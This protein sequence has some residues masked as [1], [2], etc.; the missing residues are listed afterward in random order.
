MRGLKLTYSTLGQTRNEA[1]VD[2]LIAALDDPEQ[3]HRDYALDALIKR[4]EERAPELLFKS[5]D[6]VKVEDLPKLRKQKDWV[7]KPIE[8]ALKENGDSIQNAIEAA[9]ALELTTAVTNLAMIAESSA[10]AELK[11]KCSEAIIELVRPLGAA[12]RDDRNQ[13]TVRGPVQQRLFDSVSRFSMHRNERLVDAFLLVSTWG[14]NDLRQMVQETDGPHMELLSSR[15]TQTEEPGILEL[16]AGYIRH[17]NMPH[18]I[19]P[20]LKARGDAKFRNVLLEEVGAEPNS[21]LLRNLGTIGMP[22]CCRGGERL[23]DEVP[24]SLYAALIQ[25][26]AAASDDVQESLQLVA[27]AVVRGGPGVETAAAHAFMRSDV[28]ATEFWMRAAMP[29]GDGDE[30]KIDRDPN[31][32]LLKNL[33]KLLGH[34]NPGLVKSVRRVLEPLHVEQMLSRFQPLRRRSRRR[35]GKVVLMIDPESVEKVKDTLQHSVLSY[36]L[37]AIAAADAFDV[38]DDLADSFKRIIRDDQ[39]EAR[40]RA[41]EALGE[42]SHPN[43]LRLLEEMANLPECPVKDAALV[44]IERRKRQSYTNSSLD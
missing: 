30:A 12:A 21:T 35:L 3:S 22:K 38:V 39:Q 15:L 7:R 23:L 42:A 11:T 33:I 8:A 2:V 28:P 41:V 16:L 37:D 44:A 31:A 32:R 26:S 4:E 9:V 14:D 19:C 6:K 10:S 13:P 17:K 29:V 24:K 25:L 43:T 27:S 40:L 1:A 5:W 34:S 18:G 36:R 20:H